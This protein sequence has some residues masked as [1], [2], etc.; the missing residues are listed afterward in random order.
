[1]PARYA[2]YFA[3][4]DGS[5]LATFGQ[6]WLGR[7]AVT[8]E[9]LVQ[10]TVPGLTTGRV[11]ALTAFSR[12]YGFHGT[13]KAPFALAPGVDRAALVARLACFAA[14]QPT[15][16]LPTLTVAPPDPFITLVPCAPC[17]AIDRLAAACVEAFDD[18]RASMTAADR[19]RRKTTDLS[20]RQQAYLERWGYP[21]VFDEFH[22]HLTLAGPVDDPTERD[23]LHAAAVDRSA[24]V[25]RDP[26]PVTSLCLFEQP[27]TDTPF[28]LTH[29]VMLGTAETPS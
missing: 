9:P 16:T 5:D 14:D 19:Q 24:A 3:P 17:P 7:D 28:R 10:P 11:H 26:V 23:C 12:R 13:L 25:C 27:D 20:P 22:F 1:M 15:F 6:R 8:G 18:L 21:Y 2:L 29:R 4:P